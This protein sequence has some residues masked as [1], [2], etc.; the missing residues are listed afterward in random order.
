[1]TRALLIGKEPA[2]ELG[3][4]VSAF[5]IMP[6]LFYPFLLLASSLVF[7]FLVPDKRGHESEKA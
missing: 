5:Q 2:A 1:M 7:I 3:Y 4:A 6:F